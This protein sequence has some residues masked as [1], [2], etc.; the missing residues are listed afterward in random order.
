MLALGLLL[1]GGGAVA[2]QVAAQN[3]T[4][5][6]TPA[7]TSVTQDQ[8]VQD[9]AGQGSIAVKETANEPGEQD[10]SQAL[11]GLAKIT[12]DQAK[13]IAE[14]N[15]GST[16]SDVKLENENGSLVYAVKIGAQEVKV[17]AGD[18]SILKIEQADNEKNGDTGESETGNQNEASGE[19]ED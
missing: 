15:V 5:T 4:A 12:A 1:G 13:Q 9:P 18:G 2:Y 7:L 14:A 19:I 3:N 11:T 16:A 8:E 17:D 6:Q 10:E